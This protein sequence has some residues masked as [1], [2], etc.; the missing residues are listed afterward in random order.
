MN[1]SEI[2]KTLYAEIDKMTP[3]EVFLDLNSVKCGPLS[4]AM[5]PSYVQDKI[6]SYQKM[7]ISVRKIREKTQP[8]SSLKN[9][10]WHDFFENSASNARNDHQFNLDGTQELDYDIAA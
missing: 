8:F 2:W 9:D 5:D 7:T 3:E 1:I 10:V 4:I 6:F